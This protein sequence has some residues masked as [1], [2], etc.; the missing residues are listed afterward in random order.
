M[1]A[2]REFGVELPD[3][4]ADKMATGGD[5]IAYLQKNARQ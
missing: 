2:E 4:A 1:A 5:A 3:D